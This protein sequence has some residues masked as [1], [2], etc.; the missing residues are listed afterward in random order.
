MKLDKDLVREILLRQFD[1][2]AI[3]VFGSS[4]L[5]IPVRTL[6]RSRLQSDCCA[7]SF[8]AALDV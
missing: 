6:T 2:D 3:G 5:N 8:S 4:G 7:R 1:Q